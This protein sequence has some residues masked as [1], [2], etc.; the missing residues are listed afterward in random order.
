VYI[1]DKWLFKSRIKENKNMENNSV[2]NELNDLL[3][4]K[5]NVPFGNLGIANLAAKRRLP[6]L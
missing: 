2:S 5:I 1:Y 4:K 3:M 6:K